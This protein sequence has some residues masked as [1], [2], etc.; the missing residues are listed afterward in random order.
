MGGKQSCIL[1]F[2]VLAYTNLKCLEIAKCS[3]KA[4]CSLHTWS[5]L[6]TV[7]IPFSACLKVIE[8]LHVLVRVVVESLGQGGLPVRSLTACRIFFASVGFSRPSLS[9]TALACVLLG[10]WSHSHGSLST[11]VVSVA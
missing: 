10:H 4:L 2:A 8:W 5:R 6:Y 9:A 3:G 7:Y 11:L 1:D